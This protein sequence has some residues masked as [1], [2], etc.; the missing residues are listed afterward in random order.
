MRIVKKGDLLFVITQYR[1]G[2]CVV[3]SVGR[4]YLTIEIG[5]SCKQDVKFHIETWRQKTEYSPDSFL[6]E[7]KQEWEDGKK[8]GQYID[9]FRFTFQHGRRSFSLEKLEEAAKILEIQIGDN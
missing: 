3:K 1:Q 4:K 7:S 6:F 2:E 9:L 5:V 8:Q